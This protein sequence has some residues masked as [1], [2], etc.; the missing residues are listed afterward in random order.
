MHM[1]CVNMYLIW[2]RD[3]QNQHIEAALKKLYKFAA[4]V[5]NLNNNNS[6]KICKLQEALE[7]TAKAIEL[8]TW[9]IGDNK[10]M[11]QELRSSN[12][13]IESKTQVNLKVLA[14]RNYQKKNWE[15]ISR[16]RNNKHLL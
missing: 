11:W 6:G 2:T 15:N 3:T 10:K 13:A 16:I 4:H 8:E 5:K 7:E 9:T 12:I 1:Y 14:A